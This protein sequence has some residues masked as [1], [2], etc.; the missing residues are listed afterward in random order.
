MMVAR[1]A[2]GTISVERIR[3]RV[4]LPLPFGPNKPNNSAGRTSNEIPFSAVR[5]SYRCTRFCTEITA[6]AEG[7]DASAAV[8]AYAETFVAKSF[9][10]MNPLLVYD[11][12]EQNIAEMNLGGK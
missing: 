9:P 10:R 5:F 8:S 1:P 7:D 3:N 4:V 2:L 11:D 12:T 6:D